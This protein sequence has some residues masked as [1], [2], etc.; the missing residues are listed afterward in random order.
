MTGVAR[1]VAILEGRYAPGDT[2]A[3]DAGPDGRLVFDHAAG[4]AS[5]DNEE[6]EILEGEVME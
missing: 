2:V 4:P 1:D 6:E 5:A 3:V